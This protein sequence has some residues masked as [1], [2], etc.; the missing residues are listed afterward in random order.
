MRYLPRWNVEITNHNGVSVGLRCIRRTHRDSSVQSIVWPYSLC[1]QLAYLSIIFQRGVLKNDFP[2]PA[3]VVCTVLCGP[4]NP[5]F[6]FGLKWAFSTP[7]DQISTS[8]F[9]QKPL[10]ASNWSVKLLIL[11]KICLQ[12]QKNSVFIL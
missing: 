12:L 8:H 10:S 6:V 7:K 4:S 3:R 2:I 11:R 1:M 9:V 5:F